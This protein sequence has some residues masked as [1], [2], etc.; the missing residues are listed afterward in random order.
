VKLVL[1]ARARTD[2]VDIAGYVSRA[3]ANRATGKAFALALRKQCERLAELPG[4]LGRPRPELGPR[5][6]S[7]PFR[8]YVIVFCY[9]DGL[10]EIARIL[11][12]HRDIPAEFD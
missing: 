8:G 12:G 4:E 7:F 9:S 2:L 3:A 10:L 5:L 6:R 1:T 11:E